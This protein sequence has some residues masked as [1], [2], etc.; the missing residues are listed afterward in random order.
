MHHNYMNPKEFSST[1]QNL[2]TIFG[3]DKLW[4]K[5]MKTR[6]VQNTKISM[7][8][9]IVSSHVG[10]VWFTFNVVHCSN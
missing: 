9:K 4:S 7:A 2:H 10:L 5:D 8:C 6:F 1:T 3:C